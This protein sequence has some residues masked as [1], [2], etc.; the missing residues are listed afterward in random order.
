VASRIR[1]MFDSWLPRVNAA[2]TDTARRL[3]LLP[4]PV[5]VYMVSNRW[6]NMVD[7]ML[8]PDLRATAAIGWSE[9][10]QQPVFSSTSAHVMEAL[11]TSRN[12]L[13]NVPNEVHAMVVD[14]ISDGL[15]LG[16]SRQQIIE[17][18]DSTLSMT[19]SD[20]W[21]NRARMIATT[22]SVRASNAG[23]LAA[24]IQAERSLGT[25]LKTWQCLPGDTAV[26][27]SGVREASR[28]W[29]EGQLVT[30]TTAHGRRVSMT[31]EH[32]ILTGRG[33]LCSEL[34][35]QGDQLFG[36][37]PIDPIH[38]PDI[39]RQVSMIGEFVDS[40][41][42]KHCSAYGTRRVSRRV[43]FNG[44]T[45]IALDIDV[46]AFHGE[47]WPD[48]EPVGLQPLRQ[49]MLK[50]S[51]MTLLKLADSRSPTPRLSSVQVVPVPNKAL[52][53]LTCPDH[54]HLDR[55]PRSPGFSRLT[56]GSKA[57]ASLGKHS[58]NYV[59]TT[60]ELSGNSRQR[61]P[62]P[63]EADYVIDIKVGSFSGHVYDLTTRSHWFAAN[64]L[65][66]HNSTSDH[67]VRETHRQV[68]GTELPLMQP[69][70]VGGFPLMYPSE[71]LA[72]PEQGV[73]CRCNLSFRRA[74]Q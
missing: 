51:D 47:L 56:S 65:V 3:G 10:F 9:A 70:L 53:R 49:L 54:F 26:I 48:S 72:P 46:I 68:D 5:A 69:F 30:I 57:Y 41:L 62:F 14:E 4:D 63:V 12:L 52:P 21:T 45:A 20:R 1:I 59:R 71:P 60:M 39:D 73:N 32:Q 28:R 7:E 55:F 33:W 58:G 50:S 67:R 16:E 24:A 38:T 61:L 44:D 40:L 25:L 19:G 13:S 6:N 35:Q 27:A 8:I 34:V 74:D 23:S 66:V 29:H 22:E 37:T 17:R 31:P 43:D 64:G 2:V 42:T 15:S 36:I 11:N 18:V